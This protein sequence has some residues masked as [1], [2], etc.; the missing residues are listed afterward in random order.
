[1]R[2][3]QC[4]IDGNHEAAHKL[5]VMLAVL[6][7]RRVVTLEYLSHLE[8]W[9]YKK[10]EF[11]AGASQLMQ[12]GGLHAGGQGAAAGNASNS[13]MNPAMGDMN[14]SVP[15]GMPSNIP[16]TPHMSAPNNP[17]GTQGRRETLSVSQFQS[18]INPSTGQ[19]PMSHGGYMHSQQMPPM[20]NQGPHQQR[21]MPQGSS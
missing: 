13:M 14:N 4:R 8:S 15:Q 11:L 5:E 17:Y 7:G 12:N 3:Q 9:I 21:M 16:P 18:L 19:P 6:E 2:S 20:W 1:M 10:Q